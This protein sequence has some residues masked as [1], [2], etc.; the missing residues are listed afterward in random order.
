MP[1]RCLA[2][3]E[4]RD[5]HSPYASAMQ[6]TSRITTISMEMV[7]PGA[8]GYWLDQRWGTGVVFLALGAILGF[9]TALLSLVRLTKPPGRDQPRQ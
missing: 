5:D 2:V 8:I 4:P 3:T 9:V 7:V 6:W 1:N